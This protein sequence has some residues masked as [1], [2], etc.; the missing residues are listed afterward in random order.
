MK[1]H[2]LEPVLAA[3]PFFHDLDAEHLEV[4][5]GCATNTRF[6]ADEQ[7]FG[8]G[9]PADSFYLVRSG[10][11]ALD[12]S[13]PGRGNRVVQTIEEGDVLGWSWLFPPY[14]WTV[15]ARA[16]EPTRALTMDGKCL[17]QKCEDDPKLGYEL[18]KRF[19]GVMV[20]RLYSTRIQL[21][22]VYGDKQE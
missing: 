7:L 19:A 16:T 2:D 15:S 14:K 22:D 8:E 11:I 20:E 10:R 17:R 12:V 18:M 1:T 6:L 9:D 3:H 21:L 13:V 4:V 5:V